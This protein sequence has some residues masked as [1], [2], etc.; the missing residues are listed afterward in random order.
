M[1]AIT[2][3]LLVL[4]PAVA[5]ANPASRHDP[6]L[7]KA[8]AQI[9]AA[10]M[11]DIRG[12]F[13]QGE[14]PEIVADQLRRTTD[15]FTGSVYRRETGSVWKDGLAPARGVPEYRRGKI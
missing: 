15:F 5:F 10:K 6:N 8:A 11:G 1:K 7:E 14:E 9:V 3:L 2:T 4:A 13:R 12:S